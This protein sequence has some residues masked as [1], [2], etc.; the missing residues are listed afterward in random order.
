MH[1]SRVRIHLLRPMRN[2][3]KPFCS[4]LWLPSESL[5]WISHNITQQ[6]LKN[7]LKEIPFQLTTNLEQQ[8]KKR[9]SS[10]W[11]A[12]WY[13][14]LI[15]RQKRNENFLFC[16]QQSTCTLIFPA[17][18]SCCH[19]HCASCFFLLASSR[20]VVHLCA[21]APMLRQC[22]LWLIWHRVCAKFRIFPHFGSFLTNLIDKL[23]FYWN[24]EAT[25]S[26]FSISPFKVAMDLGSFVAHS[27][28]R[29]KR[30]SYSLIIVYHVN[31]DYGP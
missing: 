1:T 13:N 26:D 7:K 15:Q 21:P 10:V 23:R 5:L 9:H 22:L 6:S 28:C 11:S 24:I 2:K 29:N 31:G 8:N 4:S 19:H 17:S 20:L 16:S 25:K 14:T 12:T 18:L 27:C 3:T 30:D